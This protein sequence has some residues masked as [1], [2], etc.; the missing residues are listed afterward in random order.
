M[1]TLAERAQ[2]LEPLGF[3]ARQARFLATVALHSGYCLRRQYAAFA[4]VRNAK[5]VCA[6]LDSLVARRWADRFT[7]RADRGHVYHLHTRALYRLIGQDNSRHRRRGSAALVARKLMVLDFVLA[8]P[9]GEWLATEEE[10]VALFTDRLGVPRGDLPQQ[11]FAATRAGGPSTVRY[12]LH[13]LP[14]GITGDPPV[15]QFMALV[16][17]AHG[18]TL[19]SFLQAHAALLHHIPAWTVV[20]AAPQ[21]C[22]GLAACH[23]VFARF[24]DRPSP[25][26]GARPDE[27]RWYLHTRRAVDQG[28][29]ARLSV[30]DLHRFRALRDRLDTPSVDARYREWVRRGDA[31]LEVQRDAP[32]RAPEAA[33]RRLVTETL[34]F[35]YSQFG[36]LPGVA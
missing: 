12:F 17:D 8:H 30:A 7:R 27:M 33:A 36:S 19:E 9:D 22:P 34:P 35:D 29:W 14:I 3:T 16:T 6:F 24:L 1:T 10:K 11:M 4:G 21:T 31:A 25:G 20:A 32:A 26:L 18:R 15:P 2:A 23:E 5:N 13:K 28:D